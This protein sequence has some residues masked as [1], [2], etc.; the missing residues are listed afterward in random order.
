MIKFII[1]LFFHK[2]IAEMKAN[3]KHN[4]NVMQA[5]LNG[6][7]YIRDII[8]ASNDTFYTTKRAILEWNKTALCKYDSAQ[9]LKNA[10]FQ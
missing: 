1:E 6:E 7:H 9:A 10:D 3:R 8:N 4:A 5:L 2:S